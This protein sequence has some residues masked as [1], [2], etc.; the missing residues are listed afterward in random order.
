MDNSYS[1]QVVRDVNPSVLDQVMAI[2]KEHFYTDPYNPEY[3]NGG[4]QELLDAQKIADIH[5]RDETSKFAL[6]FHFQ[7]LIAYAR[8]SLNKER[9]GQLETSKLHIVAAT[10]SY[11]GLE[12]FLDGVK[13]KL[14]DCLI[15]NVLKDCAANN[16]TLLISEICVFPYPNMPSLRLHQRHGFV[17]VGKKTKVIRRGDV[18]VTFIFLGKYLGGHVAIALQPLMFS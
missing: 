17:S 9:L 7:K 13:Q 6:V 12:I 11:V 10:K 4:I 15:E 5:R 18:D 16:S 3:W 2:R 1:F 14:G 8:Y